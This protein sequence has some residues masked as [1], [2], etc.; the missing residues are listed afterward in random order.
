MKF[1]FFLFFTIL[2]LK[3]VFPQ[4]ESKLYLEHSVI[5]GIKEDSKF[6]WVSTYGYGVFRYSKEKGI[7]YNYSTKSKNLGNDLLYNIE[8]SKRYVWAGS[9]DGLY[10]LNRGRNVWNRKK[11]TI[12]GQWGNW[13]RSLCYDSTT[14][15]LWI[16]RFVD[17][18]ML[19]VK[20]NKYKDINLTQNADPRTNDI[21]VIKLDGDSLVW[22]G[23]ESGIHIYNKRKNV[24]EKDAWTFINNKD[25]FNNDGDAVSISDILFDGEYVWISTDEFVTPN[26]PRFNIGGIYRFDRHKTWD[27][28]YN[29]NGLPANGVYCMERSGNKIWAGLYAFDGI[30]KKDY[31]RGVV[32]IDKSTENVIQVDLNKLDI[33]SAKVLC[34]H[35]DGK[36]MWLGTDKGLVKIVLY[37][38]LAELDVKGLNNLPNKKNILE[39]QRKKSKS[40]QPIKKVKD[41]SGD[42]SW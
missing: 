3:S 12:G 11:F 26:K 22:C 28:I 2:F 42:S 7:W 38:P 4:I 31:G 5:T 35:F 6:L 41:V 39:H 23:T 17:L 33:A 18:T 24:D 30:Q 37:N 25:G 14:G 1:L 32:L 13:I 36:N 15:I 9:D 8:I 34:M 20:R 10:I 21:K 27:E 29:Q 19:D 40:K 16:G